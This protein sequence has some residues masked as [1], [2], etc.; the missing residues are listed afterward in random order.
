MLRIYAEQ[1]ISLDERAGHAKAF[2]ELHDDQPI[3]EDINNTP[4]D[5]I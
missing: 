1:Y 3:F 4:K 2:F 5:A